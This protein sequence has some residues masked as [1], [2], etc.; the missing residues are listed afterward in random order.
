[1]KD[2][3]GARAGEILMREMNSR[4]LA[5]ICLVGQSR[6]LPLGQEGRGEFNGVPDQGAFSPPNAGLLF[7]RTELMHACMEC[8]TY[9]MHV[10]AGPLEALHDDE[11]RRKQ[12]KWS[13][14]PSLF[15]SLPLSPLPT[16]LLT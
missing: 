9:R 16:Y 8:T 1:M 3:A 4:G 15:F 6:R 11:P 13:A 12:I 14:S 2:A 10:S 7:N 5:A